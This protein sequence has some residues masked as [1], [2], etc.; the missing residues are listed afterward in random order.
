MI[1]RISHVMMWAADLERTSRWYKDKLGF[2]INY[3]APG[4]FLSM[5]SKQMGRMDFHACGNDR[6]GIGKGP[7][8]Y[9]VVEN[10]EATKSWLEAKGV[11]VGDIQ[12]VGDSPKHTWFKDCEGNEIGL[13]EV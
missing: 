2:E 11:S 8:P 1:G 3:L 6:S 12:Q 7:M 9:Y 4:E 10:I 5:F 13:E